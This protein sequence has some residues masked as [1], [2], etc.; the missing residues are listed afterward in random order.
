MRLG[1]WEPRAGNWIDSIPVL[2]SARRQDGSGASGDWH[3]SRLN[4]RRREAAPIVWPNYALG[5]WAEESRDGRKHFELYAPGD[6]AQRCVF[7][8]EVAKGTV[9]S[10]MSH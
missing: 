4:D 2:D 8:I 7:R 1:N 5:P 6:S 9:M 10:A 3:S